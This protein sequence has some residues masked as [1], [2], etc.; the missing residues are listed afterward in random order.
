MDLPFADGS[1]DVVLCIESSHCFADF[2]R[3]LAEVRRVLRPGGRFSLADL[4][5][6]ERSLAYPGGGSAPAAP[7]GRPARLR[8]APGPADRHLAERGLGA[9]LLLHEPTGSLRD[10]CL[11]L[12]AGRANC[13]LPLGPGEAVRGGAPGA[14][15]RA[16]GALLEGT[17]RQAGVREG[18]GRHRGPDLKK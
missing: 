18:A 14:P 8:P 9:T 10:Q 7:P 16:Q 5:W 1:M 15:P 17:H 3:F 2:E 6:R 12:A 4:R 11:P 13:V